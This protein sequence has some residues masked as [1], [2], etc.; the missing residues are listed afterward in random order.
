MARHPT[1]AK[2]TEAPVDFYAGHRPAVEPPA[3]PRW[4]EHIA[5]RSAPPSPRIFHRLEPGTIVRA[6]V[7]GFKYQDSKVVN[8]P[9]P[10]ANLPSGSWLVTIERIDEPSMR[11]TR[12]SFSI[13]LRIFWLT[14][15]IS[16]GVIS[17][18]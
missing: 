5:T 8:D 13:A 16:D 15:F 18:G 11:A 4:G 1:Q 9:G 6:D 12:P 3:F 10:D 7:Y 17:P 14:T 2:I